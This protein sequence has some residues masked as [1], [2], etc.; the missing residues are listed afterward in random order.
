M[1]YSLL[2]SPFYATTSCKIQKWNGRKR[3][4]VKCW[5]KSHDLK[6]KHPSTEE[7]YRLCS[8]MEKRCDKAGRVLQNQKWHIQWFGYEDKHF[9]NVSFEGRASP[10]FCRHQKHTSRRWDGILPKARCDCA[11]SL[12]WCKGNCALLFLHAR[13]SLGAAFAFD[14][15]PWA[16]FTLQ[17]RHTFATEFSQ[18]DC[19]AF[20][21]LAQ[22][23]SSPTFLLLL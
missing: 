13:P 21:S 23:Q 11:G 8:E 1:E 19:K 2:F 15:W 20:I 22:Y 6:N 5:L 17:R 4:R 10:V 18:R 3:V 12:C 9:P 7:S 16:I 14:S